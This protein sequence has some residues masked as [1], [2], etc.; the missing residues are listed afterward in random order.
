MKGWLWGGSW[1]PSLCEYLSLS[2]HLYSKG[3]LILKIELG[4]GDERIFRSRVEPGVGGGGIR[5]EVRAGEEGVGPQLLRR[6]V[7][8][9]GGG[10]EGEEGDWGSFPCSPSLA[11]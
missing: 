2:A 5:G 3:N 1:G 4:R 7:K 10:V 8:M 9:A 6:K 11:S